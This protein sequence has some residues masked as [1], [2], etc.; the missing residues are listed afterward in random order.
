[1]TPGCSP[2]S[3]RP[4]STC[5]S[6]GTRLR[7]A[8]MQT[9]GHETIRPGQLLLRTEGACNLDPGRLLEVFAR[10]RQRFAAVLSGFA[11]GDWAAPT[12]CADWS[13]HDV[14]RHLCD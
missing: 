7:E 4:R 8:P 10:Q 1:M 12:R 9:R 13:A 2:A 11:P 14:V 6:P 3:L 5:S